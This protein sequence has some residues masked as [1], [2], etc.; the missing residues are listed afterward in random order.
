M[1]EGNSTEIEELKAELEGIKKEKSWEDDQG[2]E[3]R[4]QGPGWEREEEGLQDNQK[5]ATQ[6]FSAGPARDVEI[7]QTALRETAR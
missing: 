6:A 3:K 5:I 1:S 4:G 7:V 2:I